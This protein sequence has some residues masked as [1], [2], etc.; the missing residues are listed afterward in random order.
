MLL[1]P[2]MNKAELRRSGRRI[3]IRIVQ[4]NVQRSV[5]Q[6]DPVIYRTRPGFGFRYVQ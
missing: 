3:I 1:A 4:Q 2:K 6:M 5:K